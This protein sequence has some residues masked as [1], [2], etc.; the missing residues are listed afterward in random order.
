MKNQ[1]NEILNYENASSKLSA[2]DSTKDSIGQTSLNQK[3]TV[4]IYHG[5]IFN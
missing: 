1:I 2:R 5:I 4:L 3:H